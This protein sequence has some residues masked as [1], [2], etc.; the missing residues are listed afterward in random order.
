MEGWVKN[1]SAATRVAAEVQVPSLARCCG[2]KNL[3][4]LQ[5]WHRSKLRL[6][7]NPWPGNFHVPWVGHEKKILI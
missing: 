7:L 4:L 1:L 3:V 5:L 2:L 6:G